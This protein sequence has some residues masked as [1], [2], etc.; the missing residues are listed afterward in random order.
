MI[1]GGTAESARSN[2]LEI[3]N[4]GLSVSQNAFV[5]TANGYVGIGT[6]KIALYKGQKVIK[7]NIDE[8]DALDALINLIKA[9]G[10]W[11]DIKEV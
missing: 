5:V 3:G 10:D 1:G 4:A 11:R 9:N 7:T 8:S 2:I 6:G